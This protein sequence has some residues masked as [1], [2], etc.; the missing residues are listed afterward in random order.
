LIFWGRP[1]KKRK[2][3][4][5]GRKVENRIEGVLAVGETGPRT[6]RITDA[7]QG[8]QH[9]ALT[10]ASGTHNVMK[11]EFL[12]PEAKKGLCRPGGPAS[13]GKEVAL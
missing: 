9:G 8:L 2:P 5:K 3:S 4:G 13:E 10:R 1:K 12:Q 11:S 7:L 6:G